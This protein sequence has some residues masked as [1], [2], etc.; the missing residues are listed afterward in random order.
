MLDA[1]HGEKMLNY[2]QIRAFHA[3]AR[4]GSMSRAARTLGVSQPTLSEQIKG[5][6][7]HYQVRLFAREGRALVLTGL[8]HE[9]YGLTVRLAD[10]TDQIQALLG[11]RSTVDLGGALQV[12]A[13]GPLH[14][15]S[16][17]ARFR[18]QYPQPQISLAV[19]N[20]PAALKQITDGVA[21]IGIVADPKVI[22]GLHFVPIGEDPLVAV[23]AIDHP[24]AAL[25]VVPIAALANTT[26]LLR[27]PGSTTRA[28]TLGLLDRHQISPRETIQVATREA[29]REAAAHGLGVSLIF[30]SETGEDR[31]LVKRALATVGPVAGCTEY[32]VCQEAR[33]RRPILRA[34][35]ELAE[36]YGAEW[37]G[38]KTL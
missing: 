14:A 8:G 35:L 22:P 7:A 11:E 36:A 24:F 4:E 37:R 31:R 21:D 3:V 30:D 5:L 33:R 38:G 12:V 32:V 18:K 16:L 15:A 19:T 25:D 1:G 10:V 17:L 20:A 28:V 9:L 29:I 13:D 2:H 26:L 34:F 27:E 23:M 6:E